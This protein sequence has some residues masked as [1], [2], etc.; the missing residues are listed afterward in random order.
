MEGGEGL[1]WK[2][3]KGPKKKKVLYL[4]DCEWAPCSL[5]APHTLIEYKRPPP[6]SV[7]A[8]TTG[9]LSICSAAAADY[10]R[11]VRTGLRCHTRA[12][13]RQ[14]TRKK[15]RMQCMQ[16]IYSFGL[17]STYRPSCSTFRSTNESFSSSCEEQEQRSDLN[18]FII[19]CQIQ[20]HTRGA[21]LER[22]ELCLALM[23][24]KVI[25]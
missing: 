25:P 20:T 6:P 22:I 2:D 14:K 13:S 10:N 16:C 9:G 15:R 21:G 1:D 23:H 17:Y 24:P 19:Y 5:P 11:A 12:H 7:R 4:T 8:I 18:V 3:P